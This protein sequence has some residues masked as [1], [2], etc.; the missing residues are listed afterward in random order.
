[1]SL[2]RITKELILLSLVA[3]VTVAGMTVVKADGPATAVG[4]T[5]YVTG[6]N[7]AGCASCATTGGCCS[8]DGT[9]CSGPCPPPL[10]HCTPKPP[11]IKFKCTCGKPICNPCDLQGYGY[12]PTCW[13][14]WTP[15]LS[16]GNGPAQFIAAPLLPPAVTMPP[17][18]PMQPRTSDGLPVPP[19]TNGD[20]LPIPQKDPGDSLPP[21]D[22]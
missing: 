13:R 1:M 11:K 5:G 3:F 17:G 22:R 4:A 15:P 21:S 16:C 19:K 18:Q 8:Q 6:G 2:Q 9:C 14:P 10:I 20:T 12:N 7:V